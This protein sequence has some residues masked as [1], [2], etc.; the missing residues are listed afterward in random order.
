MAHKS[1]FKRQLVQFIRENYMRNRLHKVPAET[2]AQVA[3]E[4]M[5]KYVDAVP[6]RKWGKRN[7]EATEPQPPPR[8]PRRRKAKGATHTKKPFFPEYPASIRYMYP[9]EEYE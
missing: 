6:R 3:I 2:L 7:D 9:P 4:S 1:V 8:K 5:E